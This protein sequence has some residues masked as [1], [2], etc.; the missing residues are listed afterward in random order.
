MRFRD[1]IRF[2]LGSALTTLQAMYPNS[3]LSVAA[4]S[5]LVAGVVPTAANAAASEPVWAEGGSVRIVTDGL[6]DEAG[7]VRGALEITL[8]EGWKTYWRD[9]GESGIPPVVTV[10]SPQ[11]EALIAFPAPERFDDG[12]SV[13]AGYD[14]PVALPLTFELSGMNA[15]TLLDV[16]VFLGIC[17]E[18]CIP[19]QADLSLDLS[20]NAESERAIVEQAFAALPEPAREGFAARLSGIE[21]ERLVIEADVPGAG[22]AEAT[23][24]VA[25]AGDWGFGVPKLI[26]KSGMLEFEVP[27]FMA[28]EEPNNAET[29]H[30]T[31]V[32]GDQAVSGTFEVSRQSQ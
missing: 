14:E 15:T 5:L 10:V 18:I 6:P 4:L 12:Y 13:W 31:L 3:L 9:P 7:R 20:D 17:D 11:G 16:S 23:L 24:F 22:A 25:S 27:V 28:P 19:V 30:Y 21:S 1:Q 2:A 32:S 26:S 29:I 8:D